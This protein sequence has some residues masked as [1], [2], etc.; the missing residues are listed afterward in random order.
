M[1]NKVVAAKTKK[2]QKAKVV[3]RSINDK[4]AAAGSVIADVVTQPS[5]IS[6]S[7]PA[8]GFRE[9][10]KGGYRAFLPG[11]AAKT[12]HTNPFGIRPEIQN[13]FFR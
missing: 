2:G 13:Q 5:G 4:T 3:S 7:S 9:L 12:N 11:P 1:L 6:V 10:T 8:P